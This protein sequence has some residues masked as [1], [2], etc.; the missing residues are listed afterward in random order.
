VQIKT[1]ERREHHTG[2]LQTWLRL[3][4]PPLAWMGVIFAG[5]SQSTLPS[6]TPG[7]P[8]LQ[9]I[10]G[11]LTEYAI[12]A[13]L[14]YRALRGTQEVRRPALWAFFL[15][16]GYSIS[17][18]WHQTFVPGRDGTPI[19]VGI[20]VIGASLALFWLRRFVVRHEA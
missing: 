4:L 7:V 11:H 6:L 16:L 20:D 9:D 14:F 18:E 10:L 19:D 12:L 5:S 17:D 15:T 1:P 2:K 3:W 13:T 8:D